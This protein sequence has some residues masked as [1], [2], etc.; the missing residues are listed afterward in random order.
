MADERTVKY[1]SV[2]EQ[3]NAKMAA[4]LPESTK[5]EV[6][7]YVYKD[8]K[9]QEKV[10][11]NSSVIGRIQ[12]TMM[13]IQKNLNI[14]KYLS[15]SKALSF[16]ISSSCSRGD[17]LLWLELCRSFCKLYSDEMFLSWTSMML[18]MLNKTES[19]Q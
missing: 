11:T 6:V 17:L 3:G 10:I 5:K 12:L 15:S 16:D 19:F 2:E 4:T 13:V 8:S 14:E 9:K 1:E 7:G 18:E